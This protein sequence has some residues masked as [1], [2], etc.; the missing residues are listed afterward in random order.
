MIEQ[1]ALTDRARS[2]FSAKQDAKARGQ[3]GNINVAPNALFQGLVCVLRVSKG[4]VFSP[5]KAEGQTFILLSSHRLNA[6]P[7]SLLKISRY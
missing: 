3:S 6:M 4:F 7:S 5:L 2:G 1:I